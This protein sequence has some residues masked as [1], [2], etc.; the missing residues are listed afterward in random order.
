MGEDFRSQLAR[1]A[2]LTI[3]GSPRCQ[4]YI[5][6]ATQLAR[7]DMRATD[8]IARDAVGLADAVIAELNRDEEARGK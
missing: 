1:D 3:L 2:A 5:D 4:V 8:L 6:R 7:D